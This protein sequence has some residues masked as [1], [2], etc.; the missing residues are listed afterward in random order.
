MDP[1][2]NPFSPGAGAPPPELAG[3]DDVIQAAKIALHRIRLGRPEK[4]QMLLGLR[5]VGKTVLLNK[6]SSLA[7]ELGFHVVMLEAPE[8]QR[9]AQYLA[10]ALK[11]TLLKLSR[12]EKAKDYAAHA[13]GALRGF[14][15]AFK[16]SIGEVEVAVTEP[17]SSDSGNLEV[18]LPELLLAIGRAAK[19]AESSVALLVDEVQYLSEEDLRALIVALHRISQQGLPLVMFGAGLPQVAAL[20]GDAKSYAERLFDYPAIGPLTSEAAKSAV[21]EPVREEGADI[22]H[23]ALENIVSVT[24]G[25]PYFLQEW[26]KHSWNMAQESPITPDDVD[27]A[28][29]SATAALDKSFFRVRFDRLTPREQ[30]YL[31]AMAELGPGPHR[32]GAIAEALDSTVEKMGPLRSGL[33]RKGMIWSPAHGDTAFTVPMFDEFMRRAI[34]EWVPKKASKRHVGNH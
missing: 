20:A 15:S 7:E 4:S 27:A 24:H 19:A 33:I 8:G 22:E 34:P 31:R 11:S 1:L 3:R 28:S 21:R 14:A 10:P 26:G 6:I 18:D 23:G 25:Y 16:V 9:L 32:S 17:P 2:R 30:D 5:G 29:T 12:I 13:I